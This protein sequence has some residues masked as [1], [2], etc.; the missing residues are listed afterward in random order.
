MICC[1]PNYS[2]DDFSSQQFSSNPYEVDITHFNLHHLLGGG[3]FGIVQHAVKITGHDQNKCYAIK[4]TSKSS[5]L[6]R[7][8]GLQSIYSEL[9]ILALVNHPFICNVH[10][11]FQDR[12]YLFLVLDLSRAG[13]LRFNLTLSGGRFTEERAKFYTCQIILALE[14]LHKLRI[15]HSEFFSWC[16]CSFIH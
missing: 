2:F 16:C 5:V 12:A 1:S 14:Y 13:D 9:K 8:T 4:S 15:I 6:K 11:A 7:K 3:G 10:Y